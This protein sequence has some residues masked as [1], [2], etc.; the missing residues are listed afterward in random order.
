[1]DETKTF[2]LE[3]ARAMIPWIREATQEAESKV[4]EVQRKAEDRQD[5]LARVNQIIQH[6]AETVAKLGAIPKQPFLV[7]FDSGKDYF[8]WEY[9]EKTISYRHGYNEGYAGRQKIED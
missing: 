1:M 8:C 3:T 5:A 9:P 2:T 7:D 6:W 4:F